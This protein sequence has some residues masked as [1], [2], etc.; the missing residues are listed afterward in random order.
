MK[1]KGRLPAPLHRNSLHQIVLDAE[2]ELELRRLCGQAF[3]LKGT[4]YL[5]D[6]CEAI[7]EW[8]DRRHVRV[9]ERRERQRADA[10][11]VLVVT[12]PARIAARRAA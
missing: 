11:R 12:N 7:I 10:L 4:P 1:A 5:R 6:A 9:L 3:E 2:D 8:H